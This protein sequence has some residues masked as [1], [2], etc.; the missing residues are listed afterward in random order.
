MSKD[1]RWDGVKD[2]MIVDHYMRWDAPARCSWMS[3]WPRLAPT[4]RRRST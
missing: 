3:A 1:P 2:D 4:G